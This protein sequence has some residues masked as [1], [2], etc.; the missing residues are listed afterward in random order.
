VLLVMSDRAL[1][2]WM[3][4]EFKL[5][6]KAGLSIL[7]LGSNAE[8]ALTSNVNVDVIAWSRS[9]GA[10]AGVTLEGSLIKPRESYNEAYYGK[11]IHPRDI[12]KGEVM[13]PDADMLRR[14]LAALPPDQP[15]APPPA[16]P[17]G[18]YQGQYQA[19]PPPAPPQAQPLGQVE[20]QPLAAPPRQ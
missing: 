2:A 12:L 13:N 5:G 4:D 1:A 15:N 3:D 9:K 20:T 7:M 6:A 19:A 14:S 10:Y 11:R 18:Q 8:A 17:Q 16:P